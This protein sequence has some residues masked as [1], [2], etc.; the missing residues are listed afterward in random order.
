M[1]LTRSIRRKLSIIMV[2]VAAILGVLSFSGLRGMWAYRDSIAEFSESLR[3]ARQWN[4]LVTAANPLLDALTN[5]H[6]G[7]LNRGK[8]VGEQIAIV[9]KA[10]SEL[11]ADIRRAPISD[12]KVTVLPL[13]EGHLNSLNEHL[14]T[15]R[16]MSKDLTSREKIDAAVQTV[17]TIQKLTASL[18]NLSSGF[19][20]TLREAKQVYNA[21]VTVVTVCSGIAVVLMTLMFYFIARWI[22]FPI[23][24]L[25]H[26]TKSVAAGNYAVRVHL[27]GQDEIVDLANAWNDMVA[28]FQEI[29]NELDR[30]VEERS[31]QLLR[32]ERMAGIGFLAAGVAHEINNPLSAIS[33]AAESLN[34]RL[35]AH[36]DKSEPWCEDDLSAFERYLTMIR[37]E[38]F[39][40]QQITS[41]LLDFA[42]GQDAPKSRQ[43][44]VKVIQDVTEMVKHLTQYRGHKVVFEPKQA[45][46]V[47]MN[48]AEMK[49]VLLNLVANSLESLE[50]AGEVKIELAELTDE[51]LIS[52]RDNG[53]GMTPNVLENL[54]QPFFTNRRSGK[55]TGL[56][57]SIS[58]RIVNDHGGRIEPRSDGPG[59][60]ST[61]LIHLPRPLARRAAA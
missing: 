10:A 24:E 18:P 6:L 3:S 59:C 41:R 1:V 9:E 7:T 17:G 12:A 29:K 32:S 2:L 25:H 23:R 52:I 22:F 14:A 57:L 34:D 39:R 55:G 46:L 19:E 26:G 33:M 61:F 15:L 56:G 31:R 47:E 13:V 11:R 36:P 40:C 50:G 53:C 27:S 20:R 49:Q 30:K 35:N 51:V 28:R 21:K 38:S 4:Q 44:L 16:E 43:D 45:C 8:I 37:Q 58:N 5:P 60:G 42:R 54:F 48:C